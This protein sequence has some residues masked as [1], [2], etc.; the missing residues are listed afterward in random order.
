MRPA[1]GHPL[2]DIHE[3]LKFAAMV[4]LQVYNTLQVLEEKERLKQTDIL[5]IGGERLMSDWKRTFNLFREL[6]ILLTG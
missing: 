1:S 2:S 6:S 4:P 5:I 3:P